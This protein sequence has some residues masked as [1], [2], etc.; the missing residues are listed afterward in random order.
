MGIRPPFE[1]KKP[2]LLHTR[3][4]EKN[5]PKAEAKRPASENKEA[6]RFFFDL[7]SAH[8][9]P[10]CMVTESKVQRSRG[11]VKDLWDQ[12]FTISEDPAVR[13]A[14]VLVI[15]TL[16]LSAEWLTRKLLRLA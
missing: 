4:R 10:K 5:L 11:P 7:K 3:D 16:L 9:I 2:S 1:F 8:L 15:V 6:A 12:G 13:M 14:T